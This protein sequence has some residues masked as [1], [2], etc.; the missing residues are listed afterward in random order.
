MLTSDVS[1]QVAG[2]IENIP[3]DQWA[4]YDC[5]LKRL[6][7]SRTPSALGGAIAYA[8]YTGRMR[9]TKDLDIY[10]TPEH[11]DAAVECLSACGLIDYFDELPYDRKWIY[12]GKKNDA[13]MDIIFAMANG[14]SEV[15]PD[16]L[17]RGP[18][19]ESRG[20]RLRIIPPE[21]LIWSKLYVVQRERCDWPDILN[22]VH[23]AG[24]SL[25]WDRLLKLL[26]DDRP[27]LRSLLSMYSWITPEGAA[28]LPHWLWERL[29]LLYP[30]SK[31]STERM[32]L[33]DTRPWFG[34]AA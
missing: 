29:E 1:R 21:E 17:Q 10:V 12:R 24:P 27:L 26:E 11:R 19:I 15:T 2:F 4:I 9:N 6:A 5:V 7:R 3:A 8:G 25:D 14:R 32:H 33:L 22:V 34:K 30:I 18:M 23:S 13:I 16:W 20:H 28:R 31:I